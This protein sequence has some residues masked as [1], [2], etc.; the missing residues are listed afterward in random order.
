MISGQ[1][2]RGCSKNSAR[3]SGATVVPPFRVEQSARGRTVVPRDRIELSTPAFSGQSE[4]EQDQM[5]TTKYK[6]KSDILCH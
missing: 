1:P 6:V 2:R 3:R 5:I 4:N